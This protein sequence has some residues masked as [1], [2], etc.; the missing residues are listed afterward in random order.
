MAEDPASDTGPGSSAFAS[1]G[2]NTV[3]IMFSNAGA[4]GRST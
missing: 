2:V 3:E 4:S 1:T